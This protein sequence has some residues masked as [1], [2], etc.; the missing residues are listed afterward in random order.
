VDSARGRRVVITGMGVIAP[1][2]KDLDSFWRSVAGAESAAGPLSRFDA[3]T[4]PTRIAAEVRGFH[5]R[6]HTDALSAKRL[7]LCQLYAI[8]ASR[9][10]VADAGLDLG[11]LDP[12]RVGVV[13]GSSVGGMEAGIAAHVAHARRGHRGVA[14]SGLINGHYGAG[15]GEV[16]RQLGVQGYAITVGTSS[17]S[18]GDAIGHAFRTLQLGE[19]DVV[20][21]GAAEAPLF[22]AVWTLLCSNKVMTRRNDAPKQ[23]MRPFDKGHDGM[24]LGE[25]AAYL[26]LEERSGAL[27]RG[28]RIYAEVL[29]YGRSCEAYHPLQPHPEG[30]GASRALSKALAEAGIE[31]GHVDYIN[32]HGT[33]TAA[34]DVVETI[35]I[36]RVWGE[37]ARRL[38]VS[39]TK[40]V[41][42]HLLGAAGALE[43]V[44][45]ALA[46]HHQEVPPTLNFE[47]AAEGCDLDYVP[48][49][50]RRTEVR[51][52]VNMSSGFGGKNACIVLG[53]H[54]AEEAPEQ[55]KP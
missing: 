45:C 32:A 5:P 28:A 52:A 15:S 19:V 48:R 35:A 7:D 27:S 6:E 54:P 31:L 2:G 51:A 29:G 4:M 1:N 3:G 44:V 12:E 17:A 40:P 38:A 46:L 36:K 14:P 41:T 25:G 22:P 43:A 26:V 24:M 11:R 42:G 9:L 37:G 23:A 10:A 55:P 8:A 13:E 39:S 20:L 21:A 50:A 16:A 34:G 49:T 53:R 30:I 18:G 33:A 47:V